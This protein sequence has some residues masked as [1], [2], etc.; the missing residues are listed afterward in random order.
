MLGTKTTIDGIMADEKVEIEIPAGCQYGQQVRVEGFGMP[1]MGS[2]ARGS[3][4]AVVSVAVP[5]DLSDAERATLTKLRKQR[6]VRKR[7]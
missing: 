3:V 6:R 5:D 4:I 7:G 1:R 2:S